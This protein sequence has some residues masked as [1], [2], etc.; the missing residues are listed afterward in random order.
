MLFWLS[1]DIPRPADDIS[2]R[3]LSNRP[4]RFVADNSNSSETRGLYLYERQGIDFDDVRDAL[5]RLFGPEYS[6]IIHDGDACTLFD[7]VRGNCC[8][9]TISSPSGAPIATFAIEYVTEEVNDGDLRRHVVG[10]HLGVR[11]QWCRSRADLDAYN[12]WLDQLSCQF[13]SISERDV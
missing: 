11:G 6:V 13:P 5:R 12:N 1:P 9:G 4:P 3:Q 10:V 2:P 7:R 8:A